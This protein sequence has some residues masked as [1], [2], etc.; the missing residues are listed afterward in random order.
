MSREIKFHDNETVESAVYEL[1]AAK[2][3][4]EDVYGVWGNHILYSNS[5]TMDS[6]YK[7]VYGRTKTEYDEHKQKRKREEEAR[8]QREAIYKQMVAQSRTPGE[9]VVISMPTV[10]DGLKFIAENQDMDQMSLV[11]GLLDLGC[12]FTLDDINNLQFQGK[13]PRSVDEALREGNIIEAARIIAEARDH[14]EE[15]EVISH[16]FFGDDNDSS[17]YHFIRKVTGDPNYAKENIDSMGEKGKH[18]K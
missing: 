5:V 9:D 2:A 6:A 15:R 16:Y 1:L 4:G 7:E 13:I 10:I 17:I 14:E 18:S 8:R 3:R 11:Q 12:N